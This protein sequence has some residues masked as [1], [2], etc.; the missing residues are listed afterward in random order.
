MDN[1]WLDKL[2][3]FSPE[4]INGLIGASLRTELIFAIGAGPNRRVRRALR[5]GQMERAIHYA[6]EQCRRGFRRASRP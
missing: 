2:R 6:Q 3:P 1:R 4:I 5:R